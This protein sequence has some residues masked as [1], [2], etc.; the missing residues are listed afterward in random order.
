MIIGS[1]LEW[2][3]NGDK[4]EIDV[5]GLAWSDGRK[6]TATDRNETSLG[7]YLSIL[8]KAETVVGQNFIDADCR[9]LASEGVDVSWLEPK[10]ADIRL[11]MHA[12]NGHLA[13]TGSYD[14]R[15]IVL[16]LNGRQG[17][18]FPLD[19]K[20]Y[21]TNLHATC[22]MD[23]AAALWCFPTLDRLVKTHRLESTVRTLHRVAPIFALMRDRGVRLDVKV[24]ERIYK[25][26][27][28]KTEAT[29][30]K[31]HLWEERGVK[32]IKRV[33]IWRSNKLLDICEQQFGFRPADRQRATWLKLQNNPS[34]SPEAREFVD[35]IVDLG[36][37]ANDA[38]WL[39]KAEESTNE[40]GET[41]IEFGKVGEDGFIHPRYDVCGS[42]DRAI[43][44]N[45]NV[46]NFPRP[47]DDPRPVKLRS[48][49]V[50]LCDEHI[51]LGVDFSSVETI[52]NAIESN[53]WDRA[54]AALEKK[55][56]HEG[57]AGLINNT[58]GLQLNRNQGKA[59]NHG[60]DKGESPYNLARTLFK[61]ERPSRHQVQQC[62]SI[63]LKMLAEYPKSAR[64]REELWERARENPLTV[65]N[66]FGRRLS[67]FSRAKYGDAGER[68]AKHDPK[69]KYWC[70][71]GECG[72]RRDRWKYAI[73]FLGR[74]AA[75][76]ALLR[77]MEIIWYEKRL[78]EFSLP[79]LEV[80]DELDFSVPK[81]KVEYYAKVAKVTFEEPIPELGGVSLPASVAIGESWADAH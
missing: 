56:S 36:R 9:Q 11:Y 72:P 64:F 16:L 59:I 3:R 26:R 38:H 46:Q 19:F 69:K 47:S 57:T 20:Q 55:I 24:L 17:H 43:A 62:E 51:M 29:I 54:R 28:E 22:A 50:P 12:V 5:L 8:R 30:E 45:P 52:T 32:K 21:E 73:A 77:K 2:R 1:D 66:S 34:L 13:G 10:V 18:R 27:K 14:L 70:S 60:F 35:A 78:D 74:S 15:S 39:G 7:Q 41:E 48:A 71:C 49:V 80:H 79:Y 63:F 81:E 44:S 67:C 42:P 37:G 58:F 25:A 61:T 75:F 33:P 4:Y 68:F 53:D 76:D 6:A 31:Y 23:A 40:D 65:Q